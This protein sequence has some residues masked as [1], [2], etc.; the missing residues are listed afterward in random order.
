MSVPA[1]VEVLIRVAHGFR[2]GATEHDLKIDRPQ[3]VVLVS[4][5]HAGVAGNAGNA[6]RDRSVSEIGLRQA[7]VSSTEIL[8]KVH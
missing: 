5:D 2:L 3:T 7:L 4:V 8:F 1:L 6:S